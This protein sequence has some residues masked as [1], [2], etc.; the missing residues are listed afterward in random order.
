MDVFNFFFGSRMNAFCI[1]KHL[2]SESLG[3]IRL[4]HMFLNHS[5]FQ[6]NGDVLM[7]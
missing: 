6:T 7:L 4:F 3:L 2:Y 1:W 5:T